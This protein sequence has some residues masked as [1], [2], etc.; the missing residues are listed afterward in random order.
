[1][2]IQALPKLSRR[3]E[4]W[5]IQR[6]VLFAL[7]VRELRAR[8]EG[9][10]GGLLWMLFEPLAHVLLI[11]GF[12]GVRSHMV[13]LNVD[14][15]V[16]LITGLLPFFLFRNLA[17]RLPVAINSNKAL[18]AYRQVMP[19]DALMARAIV[20]IG[21]Y[22]AVYLVALSLLG[23]LGYHSVPAHPLELLVVTSLLLTLGVALGLLFSVIVHWQTRATTIIGLVFYPLYFASAVIFPLHNLSDSVRSW[24]L[25]NPVLHLVEMSRHYFIP[26]YNALPGVNLSYPAAWALV[27]LVLGLSSY[28]AYRKNFMSVN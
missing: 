6:A 21:L 2:Q 14:Y 10:W 20:E 7:V 27:V 15:P 25:L 8:V 1:M 16:F 19:I 26:D 9:R 17:R 11:V 22:A 5:Q 12:I 24:L 18:F 3:R 4:P 23:W 28:R 13:M